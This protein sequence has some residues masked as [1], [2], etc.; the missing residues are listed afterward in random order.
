[1][2]NIIIRNNICLKIK[3]Y[4]DIIKN[5]IKK[6]KRTNSEKERN[7]SYEQFLK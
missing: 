1:M 6:K 5:F 2:K 7:K 4:I 3:Y